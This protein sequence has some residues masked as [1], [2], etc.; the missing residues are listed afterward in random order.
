MYTHHLGF[1]YLSRMYKDEE[2]L[3][4]FDCQNE[5]EMETDL[6]EELQQAESMNEEDVVDEP[7]YGVNFQVLIKRNN[8]QM[9]VQCV[10][11]KELV[12]THVYNVPLGK[13]E[14]D[15]LIYAGS[16]YMDECV[17]T[18]CMYD[19]YVLYLKIINLYALYICSIIYV[20]TSPDCPEVF[21]NIYV[22]V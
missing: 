20:C 22:Y 2:I 12:V 11:A 7:N 14:D 6:N 4:K 10:A 19:V 8:S 13:K 15:V 3:V 5:S 1:V 9:V 18:V 16:R 21:I 17:C